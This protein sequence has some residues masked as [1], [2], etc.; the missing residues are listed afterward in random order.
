MGKFN[1]RIGNKTET[2]SK[3]SHNQTLVGKDS[4]YIYYG[5]EGRLSQTMWT[6][7]TW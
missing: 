5:D 6:G 3:V 7:Q 1:K 2:S 4:S